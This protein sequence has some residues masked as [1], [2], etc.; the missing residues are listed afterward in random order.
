MNCR[1][2]GRF[3]LWEENR[4]E[5]GVRGEWYLGGENRKRRLRV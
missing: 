2:V 4:K 3:L 5:W 1:E